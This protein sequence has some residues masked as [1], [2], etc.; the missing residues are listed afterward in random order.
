MPRLQI[1]MLP[2]GHG[3][4]LWVEWTA[5]ANRSRVLIDGGPGKSYPAL[6]SRVG[7]LP[8]DDRRIDLLVITHIDTDHI[9]GA[10]TLLLDDA[11]PQFKDVWFNGRNHMQD[12]LSPVAGNHYLGGAHGQVLSAILDLPRFPWNDAFGGLA[13]VVDPRTRK[14]P[15]RQI[16]GLTFTILSPR[17]P[18]LTALAQQWDAEVGRAMKKLELV[19]PGFTDAQVATAIHEGG[20]EVAR[21]LLHSRY[22]RR[23]EPREWSEPDAEGLYLG[24]PSKANGSSIAFLVES[25]ARETAVLFGAD[26]HASVLADSLTDLLL[27]RGEPTLRL[28][29]LKVP[30]HGSKN[31]MSQD[32]L[33][34]LSCG[35][36]LFSTDGSAGYNHPDDEAIDMI[37]QDAERRKIRAELYFNYLSVRTAPWGEASRGEGT[38]YRAHYP[39]EGRGE[40]GLVVEVG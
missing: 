35:T 11:A 5:E 29:A 6:L 21:Q 20:I 24:D 19:P 8:T 28:N 14:L 22:P 25:P 32:L 30:H 40:H 18:Q 10:V 27:E 23:L 33:A 16:G 15:T 4:A 9:D 31:N 7:R 39:P 1:E 36:F 26:A 2:A 13:I 3:D 12:P 38:R 34:R 37:L 17:V